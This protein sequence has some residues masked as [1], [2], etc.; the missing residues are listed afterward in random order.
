[1]SFMRPVLIAGLGHGFNLA[2]ALAW[3]IRVVEAP[4]SVFQHLPLGHRIPGRLH[5]VSCSL[6]TMRDLIGYEERDP[7]VVRHVPQGYPRFVLHPCL[8]EL[9]EHLVRRHGLAGRTLWLTASDRSAAALATHLAGT[10]PGRSARLAPFAAAGLHGVIHPENPELCLEAK[11]FL[12]NT[13]MFLGSREAEDALVR[14]GA[15]PGAAPEVRFAG[16]AVAEIKRVLRRALPAAGDADLFLACTGMNAIYAAF[17]AISELQASR[18]RTLWVQLGWLY[19]DTIALL[20]RFTPDP[21]HDYVHLPNVFDLGA[22]ERLCA[23]RGHRLA[24]IFAETPTNPLIQT[25]DVPALAALARRHGAK[26]VLDPSIASLFCADVLAHADVLVDSL[27]KFAASEGDVIAGLVAVNPAAPD[28]E[29]LRRRIAQKLEPVYPRDLARLAAQI[30]DYE[31]LMA[32]LNAATPRIAAFLESH[33]K[34]KR[35]YWPL[36]PESRANYRRIA[37][38][39]DAVGGMLSFTL[40]APLAPFYDAVRLPK[41]PSFG[42]KNSLL[43]PFIYIAHYDLVK[44]AAGRAELAA[45]G[46]DP[47]LLRLSV[48]CEPVDDIIATL[49]EALER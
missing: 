47:E 1:M 46:I 23:E 30:G 5:A 33:P 37:R 39:P 36:A 28:A 34:V 22:L 49:A 19:R 4:M 41:G 43:S 12:Q 15:R 25:P 3:E 26:L 35:V 40:N 29:E 18:G 2:F 44:S 24:G 38:T 17:R 8:R 9:T 32:K 10:A 13:G 48:G 45:S 42:M 21:A 14:L 16:D 6:P 11:T 31:P 7:A 20:Q 27:T